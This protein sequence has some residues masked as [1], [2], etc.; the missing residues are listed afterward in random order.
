MLFFL[1]L[2]SFLSSASSQ[3]SGWVADTFNPPSLP[4]AV[5]SP[6][7]NVWAPQGSGSAQ[8]SKAWPRIWDDT[9]NVSSVLVLIGTKK[10]VIPMIPVLKFNNYSRLSV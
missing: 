8:L 9:L 3:A 6:Y 1:V 5:K 7:V 4:L 2:F 10:K